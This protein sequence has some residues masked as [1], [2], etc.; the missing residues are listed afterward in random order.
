METPEFEKEWNRMV[1]LLEITDKREF[2]KHNLHSLC[3]GFYLKGTADG[4][5]IAT[6]ELQKIG[7]KIDN[8]I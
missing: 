7:D 5:T 8:L 4:Y 3:Y 2:S 6:Q 1:E